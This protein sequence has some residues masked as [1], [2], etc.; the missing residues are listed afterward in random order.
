MANAAVVAS[1]LALRQSNVLLESKLVEA[2]ALRASL[3]E[4]AAAKQG[5]AAAASPAKGVGV[6]AAVEFLQTRFRRGAADPSVDDPVR[7]AE[8]FDA[9]TGGAEHITA[10]ELQYMCQN[11][12]ER[13]L[14]AAESVELVQQLDVNGDGE[15]DRSELL[16]WFVH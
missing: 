14:D 7:V 3:R 13:V 10:A 12:G 6:E 9:I 16:E 1:I 5:A 15:I 4:A 2:N 8:A 11:H